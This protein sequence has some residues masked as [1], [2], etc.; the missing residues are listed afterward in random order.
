VVYQRAVEHAEGLPTVVFVRLDD[1][2]VRA[3]LRGDAR[4]LVRCGPDGGMHEHPRSR[5][6]FECVGEMVKE[7]LR[8]LDVVSDARVFRVAWAA[9][10]RKGGSGETTC[11]T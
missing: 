11:T 3:H 1:E 7:R 2:N 9:T 8:A 4:E 5:V 10:R 6:V